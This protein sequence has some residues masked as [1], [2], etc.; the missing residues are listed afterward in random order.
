MKKK[1][2]FRRFAQAPTLVSGRRFVACAYL[3]A[4]LERKDGEW[5]VWMGPPHSR[6]RSSWV[7]FMELSLPEAHTLIYAA[8]RTPL[9]GRDEEAKEVLQMLV[10][11]IGPRTHPPPPKDEGPWEPLQSVD[12]WEEL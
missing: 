11:L 2:A 10:K 12:P 1:V 8:K 9:F 4:H 7:P 6:G 5:G 3:E